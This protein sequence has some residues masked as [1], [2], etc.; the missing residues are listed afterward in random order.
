[1][2]APKYPSPQQLEV[3]Y[4]EREAAVLALAGKGTIVAASLADLDRLG[5]C[6]VANEHWGICDESA[7]QALLNDA[8]HSVRACATLAA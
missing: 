5:R 8:H 1:M 7:R 3:L 2:S 4:A 6:K